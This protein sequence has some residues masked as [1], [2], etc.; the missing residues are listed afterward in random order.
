MKEPRIVNAIEYI[1]EDMITE[2]AA[3]RP[4]KTVPQWTK[5]AAAAACICLCLIGVFKIINPGMGAMQKVYNIVAA[6]E[7]VY[8][9]VWNEGAFLWNPSMKEP[10]K[11]ADEGK[12]F[13]TESGLILY[14]ENENMLWRVSGNRLSPIGNTDIK[15]TLDSPQLI[16]IADGWA[17][18]VGNRPDMPEDTWEMAVVRSSMSDGETETVLSRKNGS[19]AACEIRN[20]KLYYSVFEHS[21]GLTIEKLYSGNLINGEERLLAK[22]EIGEDGL[23]GKIFYTDKYIIMMGG[24]NDGIYKMSYEGGNAELLTEA[25]P[26]TNAMDQHSGK[27]YFE[28][29]FGEKEDYSEQLVAVDL[30]SG[31]LTRI[32]I[33][34]GKGTS[35]YTLTDLQMAEKGF[36]FVDPQS[37]LFFHCYADG[38][39]TKIH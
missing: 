15:N 26:I 29:A 14:S 5:W 19:I 10:E 22:M 16:G 21:S 27:I 30:E 6:E 35:R 11:L 18:W 32:K 12:F 7:N 31:E 34:T 3:Y 24:H 28:T 20:G 33:S 39:D 37:G 13:E 17:Y 38:T 8:Y 9:S 36:Y 25:S 4:K 23:S 2:A 1:D